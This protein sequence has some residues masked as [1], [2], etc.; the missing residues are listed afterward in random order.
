MAAKFAFG[1]HFK[2]PVHGLLRK[3]NI[4]AVCVTDAHD[5]NLTAKIINGDFT[6]IYGSPQGQTGNFRASVRN[7]IWALVQV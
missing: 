2:P 6:H 3:L 4:S 1:A 7:K 5:D